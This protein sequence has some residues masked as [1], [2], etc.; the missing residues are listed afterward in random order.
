MAPLLCAL[1]RRQQIRVPGKCAIHQ[2]QQGQ[3]TGRHVRFVDVSGH[4]VRWLAV[5]AGAIGRVRDST[6]VL[7]L[8]TQQS[9]DDAAA[10]PVK[11][12]NHAGVEATAQLDGGLTATPRLARRRIVNGI[13]VWVENVICELPSELGPNDVGVPDRI[14]QCSA[15]AVKTGNLHRRRIRYRPDAV[16]AK[17]GARVWRNVPGASVGRKRKRKDARRR[18]TQKGSIGGA[19]GFVLPGSAHEART[20][21]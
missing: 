14:C 4:E 20:I 7:A 6:E 5:Q 18:E 11:S 12:N 8:E 19:Y 9:I 17:Q 2:S 15:R 1:Q 10:A 3:G 13:G 21:A 16:A